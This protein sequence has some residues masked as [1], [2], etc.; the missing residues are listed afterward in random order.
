MA[1]HLGRELSRKDDLESLIYVIL[2]F[3]RGS[4]PWQNLPVSEN[5][6]TKA[7]GELKQKLEL[8]EL[9]SGQAVE[10]APILTYLR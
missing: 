4:L 2:Y 5:E 1:A 6:R 8:N 7:V 10:F 3:I 9:C